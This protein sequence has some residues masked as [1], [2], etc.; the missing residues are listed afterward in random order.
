MNKVKFNFRILSFEVTRRCNLCCAHCMRGEPQDK[1][2]NNNVIDKA[3][4]ETNYIDLL[5]C[6]GGEPLL[7]VDAIE[8]I[9]DQIIK[10]KMN[11]RGFTITTNGT[12]LEQRVAEQLNRIGKYVINFTRN[13]LKDNEMQYGSNI[14]ISTD[15]YH[16]NSPDEAVRFYRQHCAEYVLVQKQGAHKKA[17]E[18]DNANKGLVYAGR[19]KNLPVDSFIVDSPFHKIKFENNMVK[20]PIEVSSNGNVSI[21]AYQ[22]FDE[23]DKYA[24]GNILNTSFADMIRGWDY[25]CPLTCDEKD[26]REYSKMLLETG[27]CANKKDENTKN[28]EYYNSMENFRIE[29]HD[30]YPNLS[31]V[32]IFDMSNSYRKMMLSENEVERKFLQGYLSYAENINREREFKDHE[33]THKKFP[34]LTPK[35]CQIMDYSTEQINDDWSGYSDKKFVKECKEHHMATVKDLQAKNENRNTL[36]GLLKEAFIQ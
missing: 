10:R 15:K 21:S 17:N 19:A 22:T 27:R 5:N 20:C 13:Q 7:N 26:Q 6:T 25:K 31:P 4:D 14:T 1:D 34:N 30:K 18:I 23:I 3:L 33:E 8:Y 29:L 24:M 35:E 9:V 11:I 12:I 2:I 28:I 36:S 16:H 32:E